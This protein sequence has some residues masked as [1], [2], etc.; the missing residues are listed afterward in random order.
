MEHGYILSLPAGPVWRYCRFF[1]LY[2]VYK[3]YYVL[4]QYK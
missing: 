4:T 3:Q 1:F 2:N